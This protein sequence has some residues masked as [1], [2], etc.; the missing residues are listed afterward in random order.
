VNKKNS[1]F[2]SHPKNKS[3]LDYRCKPCHNKERHANSVVQRYGVTIN[4]IDQMIAKQNNSCAICGDKFTT[5]KNTHV[6]HCH[7]HGHVR[8]ILCQHCNTG[9]GLF[10]DSPRLLQRAIYYLEHHAKTNQP[11]PVP[12]G[13]YFGSEIYPELGSISSAGSWKNDD[14]PNHY[15]GA[16]SGQDVDHSAQTDSGDSVG[17]GGQ[18]MGTPQTL[19]SI[20]IDG[21]PKPKISWVKLGGGHLPDKP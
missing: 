8:A 15:S 2:Y 4:E 13:S 7:T 14:N 5:R 10:K 18:E 1:E 6:D 20:Q 17:H 21:K 9:L 11:T 19:E 16:I 12:T 3:G